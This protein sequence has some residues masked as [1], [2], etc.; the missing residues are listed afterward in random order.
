MSIFMFPST[1]LGFP[2]DSVVKDLPARQET[3]ETGLI[4]G[5]EGSPGVRHG[6]PLQYPCLENPMDRRAWRTTVHGVAE[7]DITENTH[8]IIGFP[9]SD[10]SETH[11]STANRFSPYFWYSL[12][13]IKLNVWINLYCYTCPCLQ[14]HKNLW[15]HM[16]AKTFTTLCSWNI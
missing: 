5:S 9:A 16:K 8:T 15:F 10:S 3:Q 7:S 2:Y 11:F 1:D 4:P 12:A 13:E 6:N 14:V